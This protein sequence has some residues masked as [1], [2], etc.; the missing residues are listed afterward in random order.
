MSDAAVEAL[1][2]SPVFELLSQAELV[3]LAKLCR[4]VA[5]SI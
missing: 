4:E 3:T 2:R 1:R 5:V